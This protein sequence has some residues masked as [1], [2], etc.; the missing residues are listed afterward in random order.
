MIANLQNNWLKKSA[1]FIVDTLENAVRNLDLNLRNHQRPNRLVLRLDI[2]CLH[3]FPFLA[4]HH[5]LSPI[6]FQCNT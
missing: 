6:G 3:P 1:T 4:L 5:R 2:I